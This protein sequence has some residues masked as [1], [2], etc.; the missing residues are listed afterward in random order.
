[1]HWRLE[2]SAFEYDIIYRPGKENGVADPL[3]RICLSIKGSMTR[4]FTLHEALCHPG[5]TRIYHWVRSKNLPFSL[6]DIRKITSSCRICDEVKPRF[7]KHQGNLMKATQPFEIINMDFKG[8]LPSA[9]RNCYMLV[10]IDEHSHFPFAF[11]CPDMRASTVI[12]KLKELF[13]LFG[14]PA[15]IHTDRN[16]M[17]MTQEIKSF[18][19]AIG[20][21]T[22]RTTPYNPQGN[23]QG[24]RY[25]GIVWRTIELTFRSQQLSISKWEEVLQEAHLSIRSLLCMSTNATPHKRMF[26]FSRR[27]TNGM[28]TPSWL[29]QPGPVL[30]K[31]HVRHSKYEPLVDEVFLFEGNPEYSYVKFPMEERRQCPQGILLQ[32]KEGWKKFYLLMASTQHRLSLEVLVVQMASTQLRLSVEVLVVRNNHLSCLSLE[33]HQHVLRKKFKKVIYLI[34]LL[35]N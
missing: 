26:G 13:S 10:L 5:E 3:S 31:S 8:P 1:M 23:G 34:N 4:L 12:N 16:S 20:V 27:S 25:M 11:P 29:M 24:E 35:M 6:E 9:T 15:Y 14:A 33:G 22:S 21:A 19:S 28:A 32:L 18:L 7:H 17:F 2:L 30:L